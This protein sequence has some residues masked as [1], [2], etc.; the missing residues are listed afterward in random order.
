ME[1]FERQ[2]VVLA[3]RLRRHA[4]GVTGDAMLADDLVQDTLERALRYRWRFRLR[5]GAL[6]GDGADGLLPWLLTLMHR[7]RLNH[8]RKSDV[9]TAMDTLP[10]VV[11]HTADLGLRRDLLQALGQLPEPQRAV[12]LLVSL[13]QFSY[14]EAA[15]VLDVPIGTVMSRLARAREHMRRLLDGGADGAAA[16]T[17]LQRVK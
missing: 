15:R 7:L 8:L 6:W 4:R 10:E 1:P 17:S 11:A 13:E 12:L 2:L 5:P 14:A 9:V 3:P 16:T